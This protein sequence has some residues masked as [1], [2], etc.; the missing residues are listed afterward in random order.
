MNEHENRRPLQPQGEGVS[1]PQGPE[2]AAECPF[3]GRAA[4]VVSDA[5][6]LSLAV[7][8][9]VVAFLAGVVVSLFGFLD[10]DLI[11]GMICLAVSVAVGLA[12]GFSIPFV[13]R[14]SVR[15]NAQPGTRIGLRVEGERICMYLMRDG[16]QL[17][18]VWRDISSLCRLV[19]RRGYVVI[20]LAR[21]QANIVSEDGFTAGDAQ[22]FCEYCAARGVRV[23]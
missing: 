1:A 3:D 10:G 11:V 21:Q 4:D 5:V 8:A 17:S 23:Q 16:A 14:R 18:S 7:M 9:G 22:G 15:N 12:V 13:S 20:Y 2:F 19:R 6:S